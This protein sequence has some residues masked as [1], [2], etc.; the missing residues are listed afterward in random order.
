M[1]KQSKSQQLVMGWLQDDSL[2]K[3]IKEFSQKFEDLINKNLTIPLLDDSLNHQQLEQFLINSNPKEIEI[4]Q[5][6]LAF[7]LSSYNA[8]PQI[9]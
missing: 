1:T 3:Q 7:N 9:I 8:S 5:S 4:P 6:N 2:L